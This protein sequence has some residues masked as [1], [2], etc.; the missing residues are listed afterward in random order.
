MA[1][2]VFTGNGSVASVIFYYKYDLLLY[3]SQILV[4]YIKH[5]LNAEYKPNAL[6]LVFKKGLKHY[7]C[8]F[9]NATNVIFD[10][11]LA[12]CCRYRV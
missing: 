12:Y 11:A 1:P 6:F 5:F 9:Q 8:L 10:D 3:I 4:H 7:Q 2:Q